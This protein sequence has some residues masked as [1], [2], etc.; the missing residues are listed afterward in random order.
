MVSSISG[1]IDIEKCI[2]LVVIGVRLMTVT[3]VHLIGCGML[4]GEDLTTLK[5]EF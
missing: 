2:I 5:E 3:S 4:T 1:M